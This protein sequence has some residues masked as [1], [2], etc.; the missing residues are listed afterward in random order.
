MVATAVALDWLFGAQA[1]AVVGTPSTG[2]REWFGNVFQSGQA[3]SCLLLLLRPERNLLDGQSVAASTQD[4]LR[5]AE[6]RAAGKMVRDSRV[7]G[8]HL[9]LRLPLRGTESQSRALACRLS[10]YINLSASMKTDSSSLVSLSIWTR[11]ML[12]ER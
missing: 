4:P 9:L 5:Y 6:T 10:S 7:M 3:A 1:S 2:C 11:P 12:I 8:A